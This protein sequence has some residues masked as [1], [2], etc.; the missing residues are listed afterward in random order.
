MPLN[1]H[2]LEVFV[3]LMAIHYGFQD[4]FVLP[5]NVTKH[6]NK[7]FPN[8]PYLF[9]GVARAN[10]IWLQRRESRWPAGPSG[11]P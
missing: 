11:L 1:A 4:N 7:H 5:L 10:A 8:A 6:R 3:V 2:H 9:S